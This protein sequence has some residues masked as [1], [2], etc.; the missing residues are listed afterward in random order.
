MSFKKIFSFIFISISF[1]ILFF[2]QTFFVFAEEN[3]L[4][5]CPYKFSTDLQFG[6]KHEDIVVLQEILN[7]DKRTLVALSGAGSPGNETG[8]FGK[9]TREALKKLQA[10]FIEYIGVADGKFNEKTRTVAEA[11]C[12]GTIE[13]IGEQVSDSQEIINTKTSANTTPLNVSLSANASRI[14]SDTQLKVSVNTNKEIVVLEPEVVIVDGGE[15]KEIRKIGKTQYMLIIAAGQN[16]KKIS[17]QIEADRVEDIDGGRNENASNEVVIAVTGTGLVSSI[18]NTAGSVS[19]SLGNILN[20]MTAS[21]TPTPTSNT[22]VSNPTQ[23]P[24]NSVPT[25]APSATQPQQQN[26]L[27]QMLSGLMSGV[28]KQQAQQQAQNQSGN[29]AGGAEESG[30][31]SSVGSAGGSCGDNGKTG[32]DSEIRK[33][34]QESGIGI[35]SVST[36]EGLPVKTVLA[37]KQIKTECGCEVTVTGG[38]ST[39]QHKTHGPGQ[40]IV[41]LRSRGNSKLRVYLKTGK[42]PKGITYLDET[43]TGVKT[44]L[45]T[46]AHW[47]INANCYQQ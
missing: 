31:E 17:V 6:D 2:S 8:N 41:D 4:P 11:I 29:G 22:S 46:G 3:I 12:D 13:E 14:T 38:T 39:K 37:L 45:G 20:Q 5:N 34:L 19:D 47:H 28:A 10:L 1:F 44:A 18:I 32:S 26:P 27:S 15:I 42:L 40:A 16:S 25:S 36:L 43:E 9:A 35:G 23:Y 24:Q 30:A 21:L 7:S 33:L